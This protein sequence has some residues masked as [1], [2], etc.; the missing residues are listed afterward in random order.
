MSRRTAAGHLVLLTFLAVLVGLSGSV[1]SSAQAPPPSISLEPP[2]AQVGS[3]VEVVGEGFSTSTTEC[4]IVR[5]VFDFGG[6]E[7][8]VATAVPSG[9]DGSFRTPFDVPEREAGSHAVVADQTQRNCN[10]MA[11][12]FLDVLVFR[13][14]PDVG[15][16]GSTAT[17]SGAGFP[18]TEEC[19]N[20]VTITF[21]GEVVGSRETTGFPGDPFEVDFTVPTRP[22]GTYEVLAS[23]DGCGTRRATDDF[24]IPEP[25]PT[26][27][28]PDATL[29]IDPTEGPI[30]TE[31]SVEGAE[32]DDGQPVTIL[33]GDVAGGT[34]PGSAVAGGAFTAA[35][36]VPAGTP[37][38]P[39][40]V[41]A[42]QRCGAGDERAATATFRVTPRLML[43]PEVGPPGSATEVRGDGFPAASAV[44][45]TW[46]PGLGSMTVMSADAGLVSTSMLVLHRD[47]LG[48]RQLVATVDV[49]API[50]VTADF[51][52]VPG[53]SQ[54]PDFT[55]RR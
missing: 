40:I 34:V 19:G 18:A 45:L 33:F 53:A 47:R 32:F 6:D 39:T 12:D 30:E 27:T 37:G 2:W 36:L 51:L 44:S 1:S 23:Q 17:A 20:P 46:Q 22:P 48:N 3:T 15:P 35:V 50:T 42:C 55:V 10:P 52:V 8:E 7:Q 9:S 49:D 4:G 21:D 31:A 11:R 38:G 24:T 14:D 13:V 29:T 41:S 54:P 26:P 16:T 25:R 43:D 5:I 28:R